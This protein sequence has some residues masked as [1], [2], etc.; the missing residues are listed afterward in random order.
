MDKF[1]GFLLSWRAGE[2]SDGQMALSFFLM[3]HAEKFP[4]RS[5]NEYLEQNSEWGL[6]ALEKFQF[7]K[8]K[9]KTCEC[10]KQWVL[11]N[12]NLKLIEFI[13]TPEQVLSYQAQGIRPVTMK[14][15]QRSRAILHREDA[16]DFFCH[17][18]EHGYM[19]F[20]DDHLRASQQKIFQ[21]IERSMQEG[22]WTEQR[23]NAEF[24]ERFVYLISDMNSH[25]EH[26]KAYLN[27]MLG[28]EKVG[29]YDYLFE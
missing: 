19:F 1:E 27:A 12:W 13:P 8:I 2:I 3:S 15:Q 24:E 7:K 6:E 28:P 18:L 25:P 9:S 11:G 14:A 4:R 10:L 23:Q 21:N 26:Y 16:L 5:L 22:L 17:D 29:V 20:Y